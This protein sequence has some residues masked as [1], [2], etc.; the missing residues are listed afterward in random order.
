MFLGFDPRNSTY[1]QGYLAAMSAS[2]YSLISMLQR[3]G[4]IMNPGGAAISLTYI[5]SERIIPGR[6]PIPLSLSPK[7]AGM[8]CQILVRL[9]ASPFGSNKLWD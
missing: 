7:I 5:A 9:L 4:P 1:V 6:S 2:S 3:F 8:L